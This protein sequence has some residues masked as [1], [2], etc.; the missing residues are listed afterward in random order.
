MSGSGGLDFSL[1]DL[2]GM[3]VLVFVILCNKNIFHFYNTRIKFKNQ[4]VC[5]L[6]VHQCDNAKSSQ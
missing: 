6:R 1:G 2:K 5:F 4:P 3:L